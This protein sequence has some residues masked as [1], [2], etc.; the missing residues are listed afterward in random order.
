MKSIYTFVKGKSYPV[1]PG[2][3]G[4]RDLVQ[5][6]RIA[7]AGPEDCSLSIVHCPLFIVHCPL[8]MAE[9]KIRK[10]NV[11]NRKS[12]II[13][14]ARGDTPTVTFNVCHSIQ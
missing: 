4:G 1:N 12:T 14:P 5:R 3:P 8:S 13:F 7:Q 11:E 2:L 6:T 9:G 10:S